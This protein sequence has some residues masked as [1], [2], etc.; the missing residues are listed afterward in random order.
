MKICK[1]CGKTNYNSESK[2]C[3]ECGGELYEKLSP[4]DKIVKSLS[5]LGQD[6]LG[7]FTDSKSELRREVLSNK[8]LVLVPLAVVSLVNAVLYPMYYRGVM[9][10]RYYAGGS[11]W[12]LLVGALEYIPIALF[13]FAVH[14]RTTPFCALWFLLYTVESVL[15]LLLVRRFNLAGIIGLLALWLATVLINKFY[16][17]GNEK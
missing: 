5:K 1:S 10:G 3:A 7:V 16:E 17:R 15:S 12:L 9:E 8:L 13:A 11:V 14:K 6:L 2:F 4:Q